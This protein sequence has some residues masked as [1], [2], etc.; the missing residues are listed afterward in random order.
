MN[1]KARIVKQ[2]PITANPMGKFRVG[3]IVELVDTYETLE[4][5]MVEIR[6]DKG[7]N[8][9]IKAEYIEEY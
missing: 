1:K 2:F 7:Y 4:C 9:V 3:D 8:T 6:T 5:K